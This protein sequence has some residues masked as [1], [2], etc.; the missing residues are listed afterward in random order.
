MNTGL[1][2]LDILVF[3]M[4]AGF[5]LLRLHRVL[6]KKTGND[7]PSQFL[8][9]EKRQHENVVPIKDTDVSED[10]T[11]AT[12]DNL[13]TLSQ[14]K[15][16]DPNFDEALFLEGAKTAFE[17]IL[18]AFAKADSSQLE[19]LLDAATYKSFYEE[20]ERRDHTGEMLET[21]LVS[22]IL[23]DITDAELS[24]SAALITVKFI[25]EQVNVTRNK[26]DE[27][28]AGDPLRVETIKDLWVFARELRSA[29]PNWKLIETRP[30]D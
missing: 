1:Q 29:D 14:I 4:I 27:V 10:A 21:T 19:T 11:D 16:V 28:V 5:L 30:G 15:V 18:G 26:S 3:A 20:I 22:I 24:G 13:R 9:D 6:G 12:T 8:S 2:F 7:Q 17:L 25:S 23:A